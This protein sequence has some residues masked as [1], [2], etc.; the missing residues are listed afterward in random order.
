MQKNKALTQVIC[1]ALLFGILAGMPASAA[2]TF[3]GAGDLCATAV[4]VDVNSSLRIFASEAA[5]RTFQIEVPFPG[6]LTLDVAVQ[7]FA[8][9]EA[10]LGYLG[11]ACGGP[12]AEED[13]FRVI[14]QSATSLVVA[15]RVPGSYLVGVAAQD[16]LLPLGEFKLRTGFL[17]ETIDG[18]L[19]DEDEGEDEP[20]PNPQPFYSDP[21]QGFAAGIVLKDED[22]GEDEPDPNPQPSAVYDLPHLTPPALRFELDGACRLGEIDDHGDTFTCATPVCL[23]QGVG[24]EIWNGWGDDH[25]LFM[26]F[27][28]KQQTVAVETTGSSDTFGGLYDRYG[29]RL[30]RADGGGRADNFRIVKTLSPGTYFV[31]VEG[32]DGAEGPYTLL[33]ETLDWHP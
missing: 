7:G 21:C 1:S 25:D 17:S 18:D 23:N 4:P 6:M 27:L 9:A 22:E 8:P 29:H 3:D 16:P 33:L 20:D 14:R 5:M 2:V 26:F 28:S 19:K 15:V 12:A 13:A 11:W 30:G 24:G 31:R 32:R 10:Q